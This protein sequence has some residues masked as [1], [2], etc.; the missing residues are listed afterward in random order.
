VADYKVRIKRSAAKEIEAIGQRRDRQRVVK[1][2][3]ALAADP[4]PL[5]CE[6]LAGRSDLYRVRVG[7]YRVLYAID[8]AVRVVLVVKVGHRRDVYKGAA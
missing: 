4:R 7:K 6:R 1:R 8:D 3:A 2:I 5:G